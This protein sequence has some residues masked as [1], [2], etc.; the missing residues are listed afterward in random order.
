MGWLYLWKKQEE[1]EMSVLI[2]M[3]TEEG[4]QGTWAELRQPQ[5]ARRLGIVTLSSGIALL[6][7]AWYCFIHLKEKWETN[8]G[9]KIHTEHHK[10]KP[11]GVPGMFG[12]S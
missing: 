11:L 4:V 1:T 9:P 2:C 7:Q 6:Q 3:Y 10:G 8:D 5:G 12:Q